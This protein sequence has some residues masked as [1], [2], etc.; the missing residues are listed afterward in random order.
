MVM[1]VTNCKEDLLSVG[2]LVSKGHS[3]H[4]TPD[5][6]YLEGLDGN[7]HQLEKHGRLWYLKMSKHPAYAAAVSSSASG[8]KGDFW[9]FEKKCWSEI[10]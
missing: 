6:S 3:V 7:R 5:G 8:S 9:T 2:S 4:F 10:I 1:T